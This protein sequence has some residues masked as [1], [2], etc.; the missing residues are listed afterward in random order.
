MKETEKPLTV[1]N[2][3][4]GFSAVHRLVILVPADGGHGKCLHRSVGIYN[5]FSNLKR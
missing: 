3:V 1:D 5:S 4:K 2:A